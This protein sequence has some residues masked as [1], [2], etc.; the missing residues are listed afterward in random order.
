MKITKR[1]LR[2]IIKEE[3]KFVIDRPKTVPNRWWEYEPKDVVTDIYHQM[4]QLPPEDWESHWPGIK[5][6]L[7]KKISNTMKITKTQLKQIIKEEL[8]KLKEGGEMGHH[9]YEFK[10]GT[11][12]ARWWSQA[13]GTIIEDQLKFEE[14]T[15]EQQEAIIA[16]LELRLD[17]ERQFQD[18]RGP[19][20][21]GFGSSVPG[22]PALHGSDVPGF[23][24]ESE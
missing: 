7:E 1:Q 13:F 17:L 3:F 19:A 5:K 12:D 6:K 4:R 14:P 15:P 16:G 23:G 8:R 10:T 18:P 9:H 22:Q 24:E 2:R 11:G 21:G 20:G